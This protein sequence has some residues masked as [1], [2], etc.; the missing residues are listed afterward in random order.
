MSMIFS[1]DRMD[2]FSSLDIG[3]Q[4]AMH[5]LFEEPDMDIVTMES[6]AEHWQPYRSIA[7]LYLFKLVD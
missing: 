1:L 2:I 3:L 7:S 6:K 4:R 5:T